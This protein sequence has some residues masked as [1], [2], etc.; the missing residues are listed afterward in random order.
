V[1]VC[2]C[3]CGGG[4]L[5]EVERETKL[6]LDR[7]QYTQTQAREGLQPGYNIHRKQEQLNR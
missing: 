7:L 1:C 4:G 3:V 6:T 5:V 2:V